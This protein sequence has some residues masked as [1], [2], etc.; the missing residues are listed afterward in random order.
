MKT[1]ATVTK[2][3][4]AIVLFGGTVVFAAPAPAPAPPTPPA[5]AG[6]AGK[7]GAKAAT[8]AGDDVTTL[9]LKVPAFSPRFARTPVALV[10]D[11]PILLD[12]FVT[13]LA[14][15]HDANAAKGETNAGKKDYELVLNRLVT[16]RLILQEGATMGLD[17]LPDVKKAVADFDENSLREI[18]KRHV[19]RRVLCAAQPLPA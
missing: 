11:D 13:T 8:P 4:A 3:I 6:T 7:E 19:Q 18:L 2:T 12:E 16:A 15:L 5:P 9:T 1:R 14:A 10:N 17:E